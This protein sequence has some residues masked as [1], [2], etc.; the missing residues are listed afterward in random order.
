MRVKGP[1]IA[2][3][4]SAYPDLNEEFAKEIENAEKAAEE[5]VNA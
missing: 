1:K 3:M 4:L 5:S 2:P